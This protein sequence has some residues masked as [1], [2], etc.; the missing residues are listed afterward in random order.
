M[1][2]KI[3]GGKAVDV[4]KEFLIPF[5][6]LKE[7]FHEYDFKITDEF[8]ESFEYAEVEKGNLDVHVVLERQPRMLIFDF[9]IH[10]TVTIPCDRCLE[11]YM[12]ELHGEE[13]L[14]VKLGSEYD[15]ES[16]EIIVIPDSEHRIDISHLVY[17]YLVLLLPY[18]RIHGEDKEGKSLCNPEILK[19]IDDHTVE[20]STD[21]RWEALK[22]L[23]GKE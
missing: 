11:D 5:S 4:R 1:R 20:D 13:R 3:S 16:D 7:G 22:K 12:Q 2:P 6:G 8:F 10:G 19:L 9:T 17:E 23:K 15:E 21:P 18:K 14:I